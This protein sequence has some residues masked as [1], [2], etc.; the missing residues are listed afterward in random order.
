MGNK[1]RWESNTPL[2]Q[3]CSQTSQL[4]IHM[5]AVFQPW[6]AKCDEDTGQLLQ[7]EKPWFSFGKIFRCDQTLPFCD[8]ASIRSVHRVLSAPFDTFG[9]DQELSDP[10]IHPFFLSL[11]S[12]SCAQS[13]KTHS[14]CQL[15][16]ISLPMDIIGELQPLAL[17]GC[18]SP[19][20]SL[21]HQQC[22]I[23]VM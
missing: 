22:F 14:C 23:L 13:A 19:M 16:Q 5:L 6:H 1:Y 17:N 10:K 11:R 8:P 21:E 3:L 2:A 7:V 20:K 18:K 12:S 4:L 9:W 15:Q